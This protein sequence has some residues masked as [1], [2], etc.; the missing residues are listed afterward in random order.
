MNW[1]RLFRWRTRLVRQLATRSGRLFV[2]LIT[3]V[4]ASGVYVQFLA[5]ASPPAISPDRPCT[6][7]MY[8]NGSSFLAVNCQTGT[9][10]YSA[11]SATTTIQNVVNQITANGGTPTRH[12]VDLLWFGI[13][14]KHFGCNAREHQEF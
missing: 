6:Y 10:D 1:I 7:S 4:I 14:T 13:C 8:V 9:I 11:T 12:F 5:T 3:L 2:V